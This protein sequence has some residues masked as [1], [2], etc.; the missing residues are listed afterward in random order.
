MLCAPKLKV[1]EAAAKKYKR[2]CQHILFH[3][4]PAPRSSASR[5]VPADRS[6]W[7]LQDGSA[8]RPRTIMEQT[9]Q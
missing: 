6:T 4:C 5:P 8:G 1:A 7:A 2:A 9:Q 3:L